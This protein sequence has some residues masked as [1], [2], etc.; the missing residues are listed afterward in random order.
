MWSG[1]GESRATAL[2]A[3]PWKQ[4]QTGAACICKAGARGGS[5]TGLGSLRAAFLQLGAENQSAVT[6]AEGAFE[7]PDLS[8]QAA[9][10]HTAFV[11]Q[12]A[13]ARFYFREGSCDHGGSASPAFS[14]SVFHD[15][16]SLIWAWCFVSCEVW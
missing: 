3:F 2:A 15:T 6:A 8:Q 9:L 1:D 7:V 4:W 16:C 10:W 11:C 13:R 5:A 14:S 12:G